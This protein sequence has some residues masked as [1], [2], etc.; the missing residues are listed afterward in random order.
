MPLDNN[1]FK[2]LVR[3]WSLDAKQRLNKAFTTDQATELLYALVG[4]LLGVHCLSF[5]MPLMRLMQLPKEERLEGV[6][7]LLSSHLQPSLITFVEAGLHEN[8]QMIT[9]MNIRPFKPQDSKGL[10]YGRRIIVFHDAYHAGRHLEM[11][12]QDRSGMF[13]GYILGKE[14]FTYKTNHQGTLTNQSREEL[15]KIAQSKFT[16][17]NGIWSAPTTPHTRTEAIMSWP[18][19]TPMK[20]YGAGPIREVIAD[21]EVTYIKTGKHWQWID[22]KLTHSG[23]MKL[24]HVFKDGEVCTLRNVIPKAPK[25]QDRLHL[26]LEQDF[27]KFK[28]QCSKIY[29]K[30]DGASTYISNDKGKIGFWSPRISKR[31]GERISYLEK[32]APFVNDVV[33]P[34]GTKA[35]G[36]LLFYKNG[37]LLKAHEI[38]GLLNSRAPLPNG[39][40]PEIRVYRIEGM[41]QPDL[42]LLHGKIFK[43]CEL[44]TSPVAHPNH[45]GYVGIPQLGSLEHGLKYKIRDDSDWK[46]IS[47]DLRD[48]ING[49]IAGVTKWLSESNKIFF[50][51]PSAGFTK[52]EILDMRNN[53]D[54]YIGR[55]AKVNSF[56]GHE[57]RA[58]VFHS[59]HMDK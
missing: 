32:L 38:G 41:Q 46:L 5:I 22:W 13:Y 44:V 15:L 42:K 48:G 7:N 11:Y 23:V 2:S 52:E 55:T 31:T 4:R 47:I 17:K 9:P 37:K 21:D 20:G 10:W 29:V 6:T 30:Y 39:I 28:S 8:K 50:L 36:E 45:E 51:G 19:N 26:K 3:G 35:M 49:G 53:P 33:I 54:E 24:T 43:P 34:E 27:E 1:P 58:G 57:G 18:I 14:N 40:T 25:F 59:W 56:K 16:A 12:I